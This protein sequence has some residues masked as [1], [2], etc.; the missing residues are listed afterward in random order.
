MSSIIRGTMC[1]QRARWY[2]KYMCTK[3]YQV[4]EDKNYKGIS[5][6][7]SL[8]HFKGKKTNITKKTKVENRVSTSKKGILIF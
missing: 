6:G 7:I 2:K 3:M 8:S 4:N 1:P 5:N